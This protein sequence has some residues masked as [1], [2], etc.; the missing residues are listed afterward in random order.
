M[1]KIF[2]YIHKVSQTGKAYKSLDEKAITRDALMGIHI[3]S[4]VVITKKKYKD[5]VGIVVSVNEEKNKY[6]V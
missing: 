1:V 4:E 5:L 6:V 2:L 3:N